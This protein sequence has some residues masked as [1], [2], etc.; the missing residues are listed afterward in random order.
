[1]SLRSERRVDVTDT[2][3]IEI[4]FCV[5]FCLSAKLKRTWTLPNFCWAEDRLFVADDMPVW[6]AAIRP[7]AANRPEAFIDLNRLYII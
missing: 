6:P 7:E 5:K 1:M 4:T 3:Q 2:I